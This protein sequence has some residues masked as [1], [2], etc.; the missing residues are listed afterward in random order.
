MVKHTPASALMAQRWQVV[1]GGDRG[2]VIVRESQSLSSLKLEE[3][4]STG[5]TVQEIDLCGHRLHFCRLSGTGPQEGWIS[6]HASGVVLARR[7]AGDTREELEGDAGVTLGNL[8]RANRDAHVMCDQRLPPFLGMSLDQKLLMMSNFRPV[9]RTGC[10]Q[11]QKSLRRSQV[12][13]IL[14]KVEQTI[15]EPPY[16]SISCIMARK[17]GAQRFLIAV[18]NNSHPLLYEAI[19]EAAEFTLQKFHRV[20]DGTVFPFSVAGI[21]DLHSFVYATNNFNDP[22]L[23]HEMARTCYDL[24]FSTSHNE[25]VVLASS[26]LWC[27]MQQSE[28]SLVSAYLSFLQHASLTPL[29]RR[30]TSGPRTIAFTQTLLQNQLLKQCCK[31][32]VY[33]IWILG[34]SQK[35]EGE[36][37]RQQYFEDAAAFAEGSH[38][39]IYLISNVPFDGHWPCGDRVQVYAGNL[40]DAL[41]GQL[42]GPDFVVAFNTGLGTLDPL[43]AHLWLPRIMDVVFHTDCD[44]IILFTSRCPAEVR[45]ETAML[46]LLGA[47][48]IF[49]VAGQDMLRNLYSG[50]AGDALTEYDDNGWLVAFQVPVHNRCNLRQMAQDVEGLCKAAEFLVQNDSSSV[51][52]AV[53]TA[54][55]WGIIDLKYDMRQPFDARVRVLEA[56]DGRRSRFSGFG[57][58]IT[59]RVNKEIRLADALLNCEVIVENK[60]LTHDMISQVG[61]GHVQPKQLWYPR[62]YSSNLSAR[63]C[64]DL[65]LTPTDTCM[66]KLCNRQRGVGVLTVLVPSLDEVLSTLLVQPP[67]TD[68]WLTQESGRAEQPKWGSFDEHVRHWWS[69][70]CPYFIAEELCFSQPTVVESETSQLEFDATMRVSFALCR[71]PESKHWRLCLNTLGATNDNDCKLMIYWLGGYWKLPVADVTS[72]NVQA[73]TIS[74]AK[75]GTAPVCLA[76]LHDVYAT[77]GD[78]VQSAL[79]E[80]NCSRQ[81]FIDKY[82]CFPE[83]HAFLAARTAATMQDPHEKR[84]WLNCAMDA[85]PEDLSQTSAIASSYIQRCF[86]AWALTRGDWQLAASYFESSISAAPASA[87]SRYLLGLTLVLTGRLEEATCR[88]KES[89]L[90]DPDHA[91]P[92]VNL[93]F[94]YIKLNMF[95]DA[96]L[97]CDRGLVR[98]PYSSY[99]HY[100][101]GLSRLLLANMAVGS[102][103]KNQTLL[104]EAL[105]EFCAARDIQNREG[106]QLWR[107]HDDKIVSLLEEGS[108]TNIDLYLPQDGWLFFGWRL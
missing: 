62:I 81:D 24:C 32:K 70:D 104:N 78:A 63:I 8:Y 71:R 43:I 13:A 89:L 92:Y 51:P 91:A 52:P 68:S 15:K 47:H 57:T 44:P 19:W 21:M 3:R 97:I 27:K 56:G 65:Q 79:Q 31:G 100:N 11:V 36:L 7:I 38:V 17:C 108:N 54:L 87:S 93:G 106:F 33:V 94:A 37:A 86:G 49:P 42:P 60:K 6:L 53:K 77:L 101:A 20:L 26:A 85:V 102:E 40:A 30:K 103:T 75:Q 9:W 61:Y 23:V 66:L 99:L 34:A 96:V 72:M 58:L 16:D 22:E 55:Y 14:E 4:L 10:S 90:L 80:G 98:H 41:D 73:R 12:V 5:A 28:F 46:N 105:S 18:N 64:N 83:F 67:D 25:H 48:I 45:G 29:E 88:M 2:G 76:Q 39:I 84:I 1:G 35:I 50:M 74:D 59:D 95:R 82:C 69:N 107:A